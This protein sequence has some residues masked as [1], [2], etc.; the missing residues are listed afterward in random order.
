MTYYGVCE[1]C[2]HPVDST[3]VDVTKRRPA[4]PI[5]GFEVPR[6]QGGTN[7]V[8]N[9]VRIPGR[10]RHADTCLPAEDPRAGQGS[11]L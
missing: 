4:F 8:R 9:R 6:E 10:V 11:L 5:T 3:A 7:H 1:E 2:H